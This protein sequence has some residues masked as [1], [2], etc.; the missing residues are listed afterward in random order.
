MNISR[1]FGFTFALVAL[2]IGTAGIIFLFQKPDLPFEYS[3]DN[4][5]IEISNDYS[6]LFQ[7]GK[8]IEKINGIKVNEANQIELILDKLNIGDEVNLVVKDSIREYSEN[9]KLVNAYRDGTFLYISIIVGLAFWG[10]SLIVYVKKPDL[11]SAKILFGMFLFFAIATLTSPG[12]NDGSVFSLY[13]LV[14]FFHIFSYVAGISMLLHFSLVFP[15][16]LYGVKFLVVSIYTLFI[17]FSFLMNIVQLKAIS[18]GKIED[19]DLYH[20]FW[21]GLIILLMVSTI[22]SIF[23]FTLSFI[24]NREDAERRRVQWALWGMFMGVLPY[25]FL[26]SIPNLLDLHVPIKEEYSMAFFIFIPLSFVIGV[27]RYKLFDI[28][29]IFSKSIVY[30][31]ATVLITSIFFLIVFGLNNIFSSAI[32]NNIPIFP[33]VSA[34]FIAFIFNPLRIKIQYFVDKYFFRVKYDFKKALHKCSMK[35]SECNTS[36]ELGNVLLNEINKVIPNKKSAILIKDETGKF[37]KILASKNVENK[38]LPDIMEKQDNIK[39]SANVSLKM[40]PDKEK[41]IILLGEKLSGIKYLDSDFDILNSFADNASTLLNKI[42]LREQVIRTEIEKKRL[43][44]LNLMKSDFVSSVSHELKTPLTSI[45][46]FAETLMSDNEI[47]KKK[48]K[49]YAI[50]I[51]GESERLTRM[52]NNILDF[53]KIE[54]GIKQYYFENICLNTAVEYVLRTMTYQFKK[55]NVILEKNICKDKIIINAD[56]DA[57][58][59]AIIN[60]LSNAI[61]YS[62]EKPRINVSLRTENGNAILEIND[63]GKGIESKELEKIFEKFYRI[64]KENEKHIGGAGIG[65]AIVKNVMD[66]HNGEIKVTSELNKG[67]TFTLIFKIL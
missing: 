14:K 30:F 21:N 62:R 6:E 58:A 65:L 13:S 7:K 31:S 48:Q 20:S 27:S 43:E 36:E 45:Q 50:I 9:V 19:I 25:I 39:F 24:K 22:F 23:N 59:E 11:L 17:A 33:L 52:I 63:N 53:S 67:S 49:E 64:K 57:V 61:K 54:R 60:L 1:Y 44:E 2:A 16:K 37:V 5:K 66:A 26:F 56:R 47:N 51:C 18:T 28:E 4:N 42:E 34:I 32:G 3:D 38:F 55:N 15:K 8:T 35:L 41:G 40:S 12:K 29:Y 46:M 10:L